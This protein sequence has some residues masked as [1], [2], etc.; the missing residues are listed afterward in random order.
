[1]QLLF[2]IIVGLIVGGL[3]LLYLL[4]QLHTVVKQNAAADYVNPGSLVL[5]I[6]VDQFVTKNVERTAIQRQGP[7]PPQR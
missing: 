4:S 6:R 5:D 2:P 7:P 1:M 3:T